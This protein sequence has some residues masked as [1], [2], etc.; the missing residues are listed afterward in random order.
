MTNYQRHTIYG[1]RHELLYDIKIYETSANM[2][3]KANM[4][5]VVLH[6]RTSLIKLYVT[7]QRVS[8]FF[9]SHDEM[10]TKKITHFNVKWETALQASRFVLHDVTASYS[11]C[12]KYEE[13]YIGYIIRKQVAPCD[14]SESQLIPNTLSR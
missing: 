9:L 6:T 7:C 13:N 11:T 12:V 14:K 5:Q 4:E 8:H 10:Y 3:Y 2:C 1:I